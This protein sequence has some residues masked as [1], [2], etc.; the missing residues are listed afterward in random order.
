MMCLSQLV[1][2]LGR[3]VGDVS[4]Q[5]SHAHVALFA[6]AAQSYVA[7]V[8]DAAQLRQSNRT[9]ITLHIHYG[10]PLRID[11]ICTYIKNTSLIN[12]VSS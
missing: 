1:G 11:K 6:V 5:Q 2:G 12:Y 10:L 8:S 7:T 3:Q 4:L 9:R